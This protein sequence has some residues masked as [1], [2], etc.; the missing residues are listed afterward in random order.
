[1]IPIVIAGIATAVVGAVA[2]PLIF[3]GS[4]FTGIIGSIFIGIIGVLGFVSSGIVAATVV[5]TAVAGTLIF[6]GSIFTGI[7]G[8]IFTGIIGSIFIGIIC[9]IGALGFVIFVIVAGSVAS[10]IMASY[11]GAVPA[12]SLCATLRSYGAT[13]LSVAGTGIS[14]V[15]GTAAAIAT[16]ANAFVADFVAASVA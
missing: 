5:A 3:I 7:I 15:T 6:I 11:G 10:K 16:A 8:S 12:G 9:I 4:I 13:G 1:M 14:S 2:G